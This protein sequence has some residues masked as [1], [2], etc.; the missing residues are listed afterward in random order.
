MFTVHRNWL[1]AFLVLWTVIC[2]HI[3]EDPLSCLVT[4]C[5]LFSDSPSS[6]SSS[7]GMIQGKPYITPQF[8]HYSRAF[9]PEEENKPI[10]TTASFH[11]HLGTVTNTQAGRV[12]SFKSKVNNLAVIFQT[13][14]GTR[15]KYAGRAGYFHQ[16][17]SKVNNLASWLYIVSISYLVNLIINS[18]NS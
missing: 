7:A 8:S 18:Y 13:H 10:N 3:T 16:C 14:L 9:I 12:L 17:L 2:Q 6:W 5:E 15:D 1:A 11:T 4:K